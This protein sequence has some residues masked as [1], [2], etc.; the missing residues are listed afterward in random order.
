MA[1]YHQVRVW[2]SLVGSRGVDLALPTKWQRCSAE[3]AAAAQ[4]DMRRQGAAALGVS[5]LLCFAKEIRRSISMSPLASG[6]RD[7]R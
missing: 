2:A 5:D 7:E 6:V 4:V 1:C 3:Q